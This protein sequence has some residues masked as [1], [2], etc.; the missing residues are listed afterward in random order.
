MSGRQ[1]DGHPIALAGVEPD[2]GE[3]QFYRTCGVHLVQRGK[4]VWVGSNL[5]SSGLQCN[6]D[7]D[8]KVWI[9]VNHD[10]TRGH[11]EAPPGVRRLRSLGVVVLMA[12]AIWVETCNFW[13]S[14]VAAAV[15]SRRRPTHQRSLGA[16][17]SMSDL[18]TKQELNGDLFHEPTL[19][20]NMTIIS[21]PAAT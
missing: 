7:R 19:D 4:W 9:V 18:S 16:P 17:S 11:R 8:T 20:G 5:L 13:H 2:A 14:L 10:N 15:A 6:C 3:D 1:G 21:C 12:R